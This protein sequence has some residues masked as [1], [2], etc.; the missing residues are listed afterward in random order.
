MLITPN[1]L[2]YIQ[3]PPKMVLVPYCTKLKMMELT[4]IAYC[5]SEFEKVR[6]EI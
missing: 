5:E 2:K 4:V 6:T 1:H 3:M